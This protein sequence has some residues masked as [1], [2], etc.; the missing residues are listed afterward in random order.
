MA[1][2]SQHPLI[3]ETVCVRFVTEKGG[4]DA[5]RADHVT[6]GDILKGCGRL[7]ASG[8]TKGGNPFDT[9]LY[10]PIDASML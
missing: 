8:L 7:V 2:L 1:F 10:P 9:C 3:N 6:H 4:G 5:L